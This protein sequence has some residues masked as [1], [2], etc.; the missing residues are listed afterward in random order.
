VISHAGFCSVTRRAV[1]E[2]AMH[3]M[4]HQTKTAACLLALA[5][6]IQA[7]GQFVIPAAPTFTESYTI[8]TGYLT[9]GKRAT[10]HVVAIYEIN[11]LTGRKE[12]VGYY[13]YVTY[14]DPEQNSVR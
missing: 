13:S 7:L 2:E 11:P 5:L 12:L 4:S 9:P 3:S 14:D 8:N 1:Q 6:A 10:I